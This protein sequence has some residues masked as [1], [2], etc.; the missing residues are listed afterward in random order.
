MRGKERRVEW[1]RQTYEREETKG[2]RKI[3]ADHL[4]K[5]NKRAERMS[6]GPKEKKHHAKDQNA[7]YFISSFVYSS[8]MIGLCRLISHFFLPPSS[9]IGP[10][11]PGLPVGIR[12]FL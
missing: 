5:A 2:G 12:T 7:F 3:R 11:H 4:G 9:I 8:Q 10:P 1:R 6:G